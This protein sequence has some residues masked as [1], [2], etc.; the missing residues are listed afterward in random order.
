[1]ANGAAGEADAEEDEEQR[2]RM[3]REMKACAERLRKPRAAA[4]AR[5]LDAVLVIK[6]SLMARSTQSLPKRI[7]KILEKYLIT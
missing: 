3:L 2:A 5:V 4:M 6:A 1:M 7:S